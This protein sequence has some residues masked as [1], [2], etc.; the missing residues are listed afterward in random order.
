MK[1][2]P[3]ILAS[4][5]PRRK[6]L[7]ERLGWSFR[8]LP[9]DAD[10]SVQPGEAPEELVKRLSL[11]K[12][13]KAARSNPDALVI[14][15]DTIVVLEG[16]VYGKPRDDAEAFEMLSSLSGK[17]HSVYSGLSLSWRGKTLCQCDRTEVTFRPLSAE[18]IRA[19]IATGE[20]RGKAGAYAIQGMGSLFVSGIHGDFSTVVGLPVALLGT[21]M[22]RL[23]FRLSEILRG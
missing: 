5:S 15:S 8:V 19:Y 2:V 18:D 9:S 14:S 7:L 17:T 12:G 23:G 6:E 4:A 22:E 10:E 3:V 16:R 11:L 21:M 1:D 20:P 13:K